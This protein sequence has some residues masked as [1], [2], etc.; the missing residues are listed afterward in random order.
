MEIRLVFFLAF[1][2][3]ALIMNTFL[4]FFTYR[5]FAKFTSNLT[6]T[7][8]EFHTDSATRVWVASVHSASEQAVSVTETAK[9]KFVEYDSVM[10][11]LQARYEFALAKV[12]T[13]MASF[14]KRM[15]DSTKGIKDKI[16]GPAYKVAAVARGIRGIAARF[17]NDDE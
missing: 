15:L 4:V 1:T 14:E 9:Q 7:I 5:A 8:R 16:E 3:A 6:E 11:R 12:D 10:V 17:S 13:R 2:S